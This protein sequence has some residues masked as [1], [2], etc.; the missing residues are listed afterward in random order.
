MALLV[1]AERRHADGAEAA[2]VWERREIR[3]SERDARAGRI[4]EG[5]VHI[6]GEFGGC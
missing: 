5:G 6:A 1:H 4:D 3:V 2:W